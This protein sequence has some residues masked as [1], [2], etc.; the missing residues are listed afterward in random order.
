MKVF[1]S[2]QFRKK[3]AG[4]GG[5]RRIVEAQRRW[6]P[7]YDVEVVDHISK[8]DIAATHAGLPSDAPVSMPWVVHNHGLYWREYEWYG[9]H[10][11][12]NKQCIEMMRQADYVTAPSEWV[13][14]ALR[15]GMWLSPKVLHHGIEPEEWLPPKKGGY[16]PKKGG[17]VLWNK[18]RVD[19]I[20][21]PTPVME[22]AARD[23]SI[24]YVTTF[25]DTAENIEVTGRLSYQEGKSLVKNSSVYLCTTR[26]TF[27]IGTLEAMASGVPVVGWRWG[28]QAEFIE[29]G[30]TGW[31]CDPGDFDGL[32]EGIRWALENKKEVG[33]AAQ[34]LVLKKFTWKQVMKAYVTFYNKC[35][36][37]F[38]IANAQPKISV[39]VPCYNL[40]RYLPDAIKSLQAQSETDWEAVIVDD[41][42]TDETPTV[43]ARLE[44]EDK[45]VKVIR[46]ETNLYLAGALNQGI[47][48]SS[49]RYIIP[50]DA[51]N[52]LEPRTL[53]LLSNPLEE[54][55]SIHISYGA[56]KFVLD[57][58]ETPD[59]S[60]S[61]NGISRWPPEFQF[62]DQISHRNQIPSTAM[63]RRA[64][65]ERI[66]GY[67]QRTRTAEDADFWTRATSYG[68]RPRRV[69][70]ATTLIYRQRENSMS[71][72]EPDWDWTAWL[73][74][75][76]N[77]HAAPFGVAADTP[78]KVGRF[79]HVPSYEPPLVSV[80]IP[81][82]PGHEK[83]LID[84][85]D[86]VEAQTMID[87]ECIVINDTG[88]P[89]N[90]P[91]PWV[92]LIR[93]FNEPI[94]PAKARD[95]GIKEARAKVFVP[96]DAD[97]YLQPDAL[98]MFVHAYQQYGGFIYSQWYDDM[99][100]G[101]SKVYD[102]P[103][104]DPNLLLKKGCLH[105][106]T[107]LYSKAD[108][109]A[110]GGFDSDVRS[111]EDWDFQIALA[112]IG[113]CGTKLPMPLFTYRKTL[114]KRREENYASFE[115]GKESLYAKWKPYW[116]GR[117]ILMACAGCK[118]G[119]GRAPTAPAP[120][121][122]EQNNLGTGDVVLI[123]YIGQKQGTMTFRGK[124]TQTAYRFGNSPAERRKYV[125]AQDAPGFLAM[126]TFTAVEPTT[127]AGPSPKLE[128]TYET[129]SFAASHEEEKQEV[130][131]QEPPTN[132]N[133]ADLTIKE[134]K[135]KVGQWTVEVLEQELVKEQQGSQRTGAIK[136]LVDEL[137]L[138]QGGHR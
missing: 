114:G 22:C 54:D 17:Y 87:W 55:R 66:G 45:R 68:F 123:E 28:G 69:T 96:L 64:V 135:G 12:L 112:S 50:L 77:M 40:A 116:E 106:I 63:Y 10:H 42:S 44:Q 115:E 2:P 5:I 94:G 74:W 131:A 56:C 49:G 39:I 25:G 89:L 83:T 18:T 13:A 78:E 109:K 27:G 129:S 43:A 32:L 75:S 48:V 103:E 59:K 24:K 102:P 71:R 133:V 100:Q 52:M 126:N 117:K 11:E 15:R 127:P 47:K 134:L 80:I 62:K 110:V 26:E 53:E 37:D 136:V 41:H 95:M 105:A 8:A 57:D 72:V 7:K 122:T 30:K 88:Q 58:G 38:E 79:W 9:W 14:Y 124:V 121:K 92:K 130:Q 33:Q 70:R 60:V 104:Y 67:R 120:L 16:S 82:G 132:G 98:A 6:L 99:G 3:D 29:H 20:C 73:P 23:R 125:Y 65:W 1:I 107:A 81:V 108:W 90:I 118:S 85:L 36:I 111:W 128:I 91:H 119:G 61:P 138:R 113:V 93:G 31:L 86:S 46:N 137:N 84:A 19:P 51:D 21:D 4:E 34:A 101:E 35:V 97:D 76:R